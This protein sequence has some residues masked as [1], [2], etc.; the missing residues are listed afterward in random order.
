MTLRVNGWRKAEYRTIDE[1]VILNSSYDFE[2]ENR[3]NSKKNPNQFY[4]GCNPSMEKMKIDRISSLSV[5]YSEASE[6]NKEN[7]TISFRIVPS[8]SHLKI[9]F[10]LLVSYS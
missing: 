7:L 9:T 4:I 10:N 3:K 1:S 2:F 6:E 5:A 8:M